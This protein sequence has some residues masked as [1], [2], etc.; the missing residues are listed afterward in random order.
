MGKLVFISGGV[1]SGKSSFAEQYVIECNIPAAYIATSEA[2]DDEMQARIKKHRLDRERQKFAW[3]LYEMPY[4]LADDFKEQV[5]LF[6][7]VTTW[8]ANMLFM[9][10]DKAAPQKLLYWMEQLL[11]EDRLVIAVS[12]EMLD[13]GL[14]PYSETNEYLQLIGALHCEL[15]RCADEVYECI[16]GVVKQWK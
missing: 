12:N 3:S 7:C 8:L 11:N 6:E 15:V 5:V 9:R 14:S 1:R 16:N 10:Q 4:E 2:F 13:S